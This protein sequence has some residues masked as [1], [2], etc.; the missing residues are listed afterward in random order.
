M[1]GNRF[2]H[3]ARSL[4]DPQSRRSLLRGLA[5]ALAAGTLGSRAASAQSDCPPGQTPNRK[6][7][8]RCPAG[9]DACSDGCY[10]LKRDPY[11]CGDC[12]NYCPGGECRKGECRC[13]S[14][15]ELCD[16][17]CLSEFDYE[18]DPNNC[19]SCGNVCPDG[20]CV[21]GSCCTPDCDGKACG[22]DDGCGGAC[23]GSCA[24]ACQTCD[25]FSRICVE[26]R[27]AIC[28][29]GGARCCNG[30]C[31]ACV[32]HNFIC[33][34]DSN[35]CTNDCRMCCGGNPRPNPSGGFFCAPS[36][37]P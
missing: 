26:D 1:D 31:T 25:P 10:D 7:D 34:P 8:C 24:G 19:G 11:N 23:F 29:D 32:P 13:G 20:A 17:A 33:I 6:G 35:T 16:G 27:G 14:G 28:G 36:S 4:A 5:G 9:T 2:D 21:G 12:G 22:D 15:T 3:L 30:E 37:A 18:T